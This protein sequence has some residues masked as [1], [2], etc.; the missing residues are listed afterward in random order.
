MEPFEYYVQLAHEIIGNVFDTHGI[1]CSL[2]QKV[3][4]D[5]ILPL[6]IVFHVEFISY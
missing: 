3:T 2:M 6:G 1:S 5:K 4:I